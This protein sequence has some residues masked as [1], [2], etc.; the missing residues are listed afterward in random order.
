MIAVILCPG[1]SL[2]G[3]IGVQAHDVLLAVNKAMEHPTAIGADWWVAIDLWNDQ[4][5]PK[6]VPKLGMV[7]SY[8]AIDEGQSIFVP[9]RL[10]KFNQHSKARPTAT[11]LPA[12]LWWA[13]HLGATEV[14]LIGCD[15]DG[16]VDFRGI[17]EGIRSPDRWKLEAKECQE[18]ARKTGMQLWGAPW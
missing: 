17:A 14:E 5:L 8:A 3:L 15:H 10:E 18:I 6:Y 16:D 1:P 11:S 2:A 12:A 7:T 13:A 9:Y 4:P